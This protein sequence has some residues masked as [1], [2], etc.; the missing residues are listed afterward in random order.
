M[1]LWF[2]GCAG[3]VTDAGQGGRKA[4]KA[5]VGGG[6][7][8]VGAFRTVNGRFENGTG[9]GCC[10]S[11]QR[12]FGFAFHDRLGFVQEGGGIVG[13]AESRRRSNTVAST[14]GGIGCL[15]RFEL[16]RTHGSSSLFGAL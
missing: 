14:F 12:S 6:V 5:K 16:Y 3:S 1:I 8:R 10:T 7:L 2:G 13:R 15:T 9:S 11:S 4:G